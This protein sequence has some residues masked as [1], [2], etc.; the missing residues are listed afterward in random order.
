MSND[1]KDLARGKES[2]KGKTRWINDSLIAIPFLK[3]LAKTKSTMSYTELAKNISDIHRVTHPDWESTNEFS[4]V[5][6]GPRVLH[7]IKTYCEFHKLPPLNNLIVNQRYGKPGNGA[8]HSK[9][10]NDEWLMENVYNHNWDNF[11]PSY[12]ELLKD[13]KSDIDFFDLRTKAIDTFREHCGEFFMDSEILNSENGVFLLDMKLG[14]IFN[15]GADDE[16]SNDSD[17]LK[18]YRKQT[19]HLSNVGYYVFEVDTLT[20]INPND[21]AFEG[22]KNVQYSILG[23][24]TIK[25]TVVSLENPTWFALLEVANNAMLEVGDKRKLYLEGIAMNKNTKVYDLQLVDVDAEMKQY[26]G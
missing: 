23:D 19:S 7:P 16:V 15:F 5:H 6:I 10:S 1:T 13:V 4:P 26:E 8:T 24:E 9:V 18:S 2:Y 11:N 22:E 25:S 12:A 20:P 3:N 14:D 21:I 17:A